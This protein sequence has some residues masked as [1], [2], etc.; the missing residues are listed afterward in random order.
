MCRCAW[1]IAS[2]SLIALHR[3]L[4]ADVAPM[5]MA[6]DANRLHLLPSGVIVWQVPEVCDIG[7]YAHP[8]GL[9]LFFTQRQLQFNPE[10]VARQV[11]MAHILSLGKAA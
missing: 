6:I 9:S 1:Y 7:E 10:A 3:I 8:G 11:L 4:S 2:V 5:D